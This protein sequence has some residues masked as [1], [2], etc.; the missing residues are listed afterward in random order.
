MFKKEFEVWDIMSKRK[1]IISAVNANLKH[2]EDIWT[3]M[4]KSIKDARKKIPY[5]F[6]EIENVLKSHFVS[7]RES[8]KLMANPDFNKFADMIAHEVSAK[9][10]NVNE[11]QVIRIVKDK[12]SSSFLDMLTVGLGNEHEKDYTRLKKGKMFKRILV[13]NR[14]E[15]AVRI[16]RAC[17]ELNVESIQVYTKMDEKSLAVKFADKSVKIGNKSSDYLDMDKIIKIAKKY[18][19]DALHPGYGFLAENADF[20]RLCK[21]NGIKFIGPSYAA[22]LAMG[23]KINAK[24]LIQKSGVPVLEGTANAIK[25]FNSGREKA[26]EIGVGGRIEAYAGAKVLENYDVLIPVVR[27][28]KNTSFT[29]Y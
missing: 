6:T 15:I 24:K 5:V 13:A 19:A 28:S 25:D 10:P 16:I 14:G 1:R 8:R 22:I 18:K 7:L 23:D 21:Q 27:S 11:K 4:K 26:I 17:R 9:M 12:G 3:N 2:F 20:A 29:L